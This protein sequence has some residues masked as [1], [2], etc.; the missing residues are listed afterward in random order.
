[1]RSTLR[2]GEEKM[3][4]VMCGIDAVGYQARS[5]DDPSREKPMQVIE[6]LAHVVN[7]T[8]RIGI[9]GVYFEEDPGGVDKH[10]KKGQFSMPLG[11]LF[12]KGLSIGMGQT[13]VKK[14]NAY[15]RDLIVAGRAKPSFIVSH[16]LTLEE[17]PAAY[18]KFDQRSDGYTKVVLKPEANAPS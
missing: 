4:G 10:A 2:P 12:E 17:S 18:A 6:E 9:V 3:S 15:L 14:Y 1:M 11:A 8:G 13:P 5:F 16:R 7:P